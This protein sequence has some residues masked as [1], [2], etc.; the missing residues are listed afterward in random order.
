[1]EQS[2]AIQL[3]KDHVLKTKAHIEEAK[4]RA[5]KVAA[6]DFAGLAPFQG[7]WAW[8]VHLPFVTPENVICYPNEIIVVVPEATGEVCVFPGL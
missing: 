5:Q 6:K 7:D 1:M 8:I 2:V 3:A 4:I